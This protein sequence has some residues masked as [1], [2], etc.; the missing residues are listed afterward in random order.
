MAKDREKQKR[1][2]EFQRPVLLRLENAEALIL[3]ALDEILILRML[4][5]ELTR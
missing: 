3:L 2:G 5:L 4:L 1:H